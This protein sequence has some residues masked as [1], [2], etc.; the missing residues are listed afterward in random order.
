M[1]DSAIS[2]RPLTRDELSVLTQVKWSAGLSKKHENRLARQVAGEVTYLIAWQGTVPI[3]HL[4]VKWT[5]PSD[6]PMRSQLTG[7]AEIE[8]FT[9]IAERRSQGIG[10]MM[11]AGVEEETCRQS[12]RRIGLGVAVDNPR[13]K[14][15][16]E[17][18]G[19]QDAQFGVY[20]TRWQYSDAQGEKR[21]DEA[22]CTYLIKDLT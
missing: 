19:F 1:V 15:F 2:I 12:L 13:A 20:L 8:D 21:W 5:G 9:V 11:M 4:L 22:P 3:G 10:R 17:R 14:A 18:L 16:Y 7:C 6:E